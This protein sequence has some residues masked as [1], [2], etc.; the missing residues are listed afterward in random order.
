[1]KKIKDCPYLTTDNRCKVN[2]FFGE[3][4]I[5]NIKQENC[6]DYRNYKLRATLSPIARGK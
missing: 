5:C 4:L 3:L 2:P 6:D 1:V